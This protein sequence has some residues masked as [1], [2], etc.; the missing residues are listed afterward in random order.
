MKP[1]PEKQPYIWATVNMNVPNKVCKTCGNTEN[2]IAYGIDGSDI[3]YRTREVFF[4]C[5]CGDKWIEEPQSKGDDE[6]EE[7]R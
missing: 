3:P 6:N 7:D 5:V 1:R 2:I 4:W